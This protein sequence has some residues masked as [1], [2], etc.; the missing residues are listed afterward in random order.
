M[1][2][3]KQIRNELG[4]SSATI[5]NWVK[6][7]VIPPYPNGR[8]FDDA[9]YS[10]VISGIKEDYNKLQKRANRSNNATATV[11][12]STIS[13]NKTKRIIELLL[14]IYQERQVSLSQFMFSL[15]VHFLEKKGLI[16]FN[17]NEFHSSNPVF[18]CFL[19]NWESDYYSDLI[20]QF[21]QI[22][23][24]QDE[25]DFLGSIYESLR[26]L[27][28]KSTL[29][30]FFTP[31]ELIADI[32]VPLNATVLDPCGGTGTC[33]LGTIRKEHNPQKIT[34]R[35]IDSLAL[36]IAKVNFALFF[37]RIDT[38]INSEIKNILFDKTS[39]KAFDLFSSNKE[40]ESFDIIITNPPYGA[41]LTVEEKTRLINDYPNLKTT[42]SFSIA[43]YNCLDKLCEKGVLY[44]ILPESL[45]YVDTHFNI[46]KH[47]FTTGKNITIRHFGN[48]FKGIMSKIIRLEIQ[49]QDLKSGIQIFNK[50]V[51]WTLE[52]N[53]LVK[54]GY[55][56]AFIS[57]V[58]EIDILDKI[59]SVNAFTLE[60]K[61]KFGLG[62]VTG[63]NEA[64]LKDRFTDGLEPIFTGKELQLF[65]FTQPK[66]FIDFNPNAL[67]QVAPVELYRQSKICYRFISDSIVTVADFD[68]SL[69]LNSINF[70][71]PTKDI[72]IKALSAF[73]NSDVVTFIYQRFFNSTKVLRSHFESLPIPHAFFDN[74][75]NLTNLYDEAN[76]GKDIQTK[77]NSL[78]C[79]L[80]GLSEY[81]SNHISKNI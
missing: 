63:N 42:E 40:K 21:N 6:T 44:F 9:T 58:G 22:D 36:N 71:I 76:C 25:V 57:D 27:N 12:A 43:L 23:F 38:L 37:N 51:N 54:N 13:T 35:D 70:F 47:I 28:E 4:V 5:A 17:E 24:P 31:Q 3:T 65:K 41:K 18:T 11:N 73:L 74:I 59:F 69:I 67:Q 78:V 8:Y 30:A 55:R 7:G 49:N 80:Y 56:P 34:I 33:L 77:L 61:C 15:S 52:K 50:N 20:K 68:N 2:T 29:G 45:L 10:Q 39:H 64:Y 53:M 26:A 62:V 48:A 79:T 72:P 14:R 81:E 32:D 75:R 16:Y 19:S 46:R 60:R 66:Y 1:K